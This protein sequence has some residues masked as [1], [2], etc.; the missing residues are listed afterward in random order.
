MTTA[1]LDRIFAMHTGLSDVNAA[2]RQVIR[3]EMLKEIG[4]EMKRF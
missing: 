4:A 2:S 1:M 3:E